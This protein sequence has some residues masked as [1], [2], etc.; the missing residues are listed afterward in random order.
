MAGRIVKAK[1]LFLDE[2]EYRAFENFDI[3][4]CDLCGNLHDEDLEVLQDALE[5]FKNN[6]MIKQDY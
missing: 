2:R 6:V 3:V 4:L 5:E 1:T